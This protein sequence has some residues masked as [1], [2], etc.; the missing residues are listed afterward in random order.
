MHVTQR[1]NPF[2][3]APRVR[4]K[5]ENSFQTRFFNRPVV[6]F[7]FPFLTLAVIGADFALLRRKGLEGLEKPFPRANGLRAFTGRFRVF[8]SAASNVLGERLFITLFCREKLAL[9][10]IFPFSDCDPHVRVASDSRTVNRVR[11]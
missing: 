4:M 6:I 1:L 8:S 7:F 2:S 3:S 10:A 9:C 5:I 11:P